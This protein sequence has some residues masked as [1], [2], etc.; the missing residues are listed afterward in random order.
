[1]SDVLRVLVPVDGSVPSLQAVP[2]GFAGFEH[3]PVPELQVPARWHW[4]LAVQT[5]GFAPVHTP[6]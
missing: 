6:V 3:N 1:M 4:S 2:F 5:T